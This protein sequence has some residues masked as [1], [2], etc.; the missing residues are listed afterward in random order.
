MNVSGPEARSGRRL[1]WRQ[2]RILYVREMRTSLRE[3]AI[4]LNSILI[5]VLLYPF[6]LWAAFTGLLF[7][8]GQTEGLVAR[9]AVTPWPES[10]PRLRLQL[11]RDKQ[12]QVVKARDL[13]G[14]KRA[15]MPAWAGQSSTNSRLDASSLRTLE[16]KIR[17]GQLD[18]LVEFLPATNAPAALAGNFQARITYDQS[19]ERSAE[20]R[21]RL[22]EALDQYREDWLKRDA[23]QRGIAAAAWQGFTLSTRNVASKK[24]M[25]TFILGLMAPV[26]FVV[27]VAMGCFYPA[28][29]TLAGER[30][31]NTWETL[32]STAATRPSIVTAKYLCVASLG[33]LAGI[34]NLLAVLLTIKPIFAPL[35][36]KAGQS[37]AFTFPLASIPVVA[38]AAVLL[39][40]FLAAGMMIF[41]SLA[42]TFKEGQAMI[43]PFYLL[44]LV[45][46]V[47]LEVP[48]LK[49]TLP[50]A[51]VPVVN[52]TMMVREAL[53]GTFHWLQMGV[54]VASSLALIALCVWLAAFILKF[55][56]VVAGS[57]SGSFRK[58]FH[59]R[60]AKVRNPK[61]AP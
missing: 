19:K 40:G 56:E 27:M 60:I 35:L 52:V 33:G 43:T 59:E 18:A 7:V 22:T 15:D 51:F 42:R 8:I 41:A 53:G 45:P 12:L 61:P 49:F 46:V 11:E 48:G 29:D 17:T 13:A 32:M 50:L 44:V 9:I 37:L 30:E 57:S 38:V 23:H 1:D 55:E 54:S 26:I 16:G 6:L 28:V 10:H 4:V 3:K 36:A 58:F 14:G 5:P 39:A 34:L 21:T 24:Q 31:R 47:F 2:V 20:A 25:G